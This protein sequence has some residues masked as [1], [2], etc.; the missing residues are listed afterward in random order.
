MGRISLS[1]ER[2]RGVYLLT[3]D[4]IPREL[5][6]FVSSIEP[7]ILWDYHLGPSSHRKLQQALP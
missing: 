6:S 5:T 3:R 1:H 7:S 4:E 2:G